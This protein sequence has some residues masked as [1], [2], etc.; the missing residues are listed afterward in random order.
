[1]SAVLER[2]DQLQRSTRF[3]VVALALWTVLCMGGLGAWWV[4]V[5][6][7]AAVSETPSGAAPAPPPSSQSA[8]QHEEGAR[9][10][11][12]QAG[13][14][15]E[16]RLTQVEQALRSRSGLPAAI[17][18]TVAALAGGAVVISLGL[19]LTYAGLGTLAAAAA[20]VLA[21]FEPTRQLA[22]VF[23]GAVGLF[24]LYTAI[25]RALVSALAGPGQTLSV[26]R[27]TLLEASRQRV[28]AGLAIM[29]IVWLAAVTLWLNPAQPLRYRVQSFLQYS[30]SGAFW[31]TGIVVLFFAA[32]TVAFEQRDRVVWQTFAKPVRPWAYLLG[33]WLGV[34]AL[35]L[36][37]LTTGA[38]GTFLYVEHLRQQPALGEVAPFVNEDGS[39]GLTHPSTDRLILESQ[40]LT[41]RVGI[42]AKPPEVP[43]QA[44]K[45]AVAQRLEEEYSRDPSLRD[46]PSFAQEVEQQIRQE[47]KTQRWSI[48]PAS[49][50]GFAYRDFRFEGLARARELGLPLTLQYTINGAGDDPSVIFTILFVVNGSPVRAKATVNTLQTIPLRA[51]AVGEDG[52]MHLRVYNGDPTTG[53]VNQFTFRFPPDGLEVLYTAASYEANFLRVAAS[54]WLKLGFIA[55]AAIGASA[56]LSFPVAC[57]LALALV[58]GAS[59]AGF[60]EQALEEFPYFDSSGAFDPV[61]AVVRTGALPVVLAFG[62]YAKINPTAALVDGRLVTA[63]QLG[64]LL[65][66]VGG[67]TAASL[68][69]GWLVFRRREL[70]LYSG[71]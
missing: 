20:G 19:A 3:R 51:Q 37:A 41:A 32:A 66:M 44:F 43:P 71:G 65:L 64:R 29:L 35:A 47:L 34:M 39:D 17:T 55:A 16:Q 69:L 54:L 24:A 1:M 70:A 62:A 57:L 61:G 38:L 56:F 31:I 14:T 67:W 6:A 11:R 18:A 21:A 7:P 13:P 60:V 4:A 48:P 59:T 40:V 33:K 10:S 46:D 28:S 12:P 25:E 45:Q 50:F 52:A 42:K 36:C 63:S 58:F 53:E 26:A 5:H 2:L 9:A 27:T 22:F 49:E 23:S 30:V 15:L 68:L 8:P